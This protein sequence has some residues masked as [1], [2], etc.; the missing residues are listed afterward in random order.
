M[1]SYICVAFDATNDKEVV[2]DLKKVTE[3]DPLVARGKRKGEDGVMIL[4]NPR[5]SDRFVYFLY[6]DDFA[7]FL[8]WDLSNN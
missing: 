1:S 3:G 5:V 6:L 2:I 7:D 8:L 4:A